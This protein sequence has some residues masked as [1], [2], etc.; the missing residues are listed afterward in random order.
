VDFCGINC[1]LL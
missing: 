1:S